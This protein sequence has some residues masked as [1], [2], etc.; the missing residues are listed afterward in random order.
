[1]RAAVQ[2][3]AHVTHHNA[4]SDAVCEFLTL[5]VQDFL[6]GLSL[7]EMVSRRIQPLLAEHPEL[8]FR[9]RPRRENPSGWVVETLQAVLQGLL[10]NAGFEDCLV[11]VVNRGGDADTTG[12]ISGMLAGALY[13]P[14]DIPRR[15]LAALDPGIASQCREQ[16]HALLQLATR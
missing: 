13:G 6:L 2:A 16:A 9:N 8:S 1:V 15:W 7:P 12:A 3:Q 4:I 11:D 14:Q 5:A 10:D